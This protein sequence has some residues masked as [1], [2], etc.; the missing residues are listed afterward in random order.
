MM[1]LDRRLQKR[2]HA[3]L[4]LP[5]SSPPLPGYDQIRMIIRSQVA[6]YILNMRLKMNLL[7][8]SFFSVL[9]SNVAVA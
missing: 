1:R 4:S 6:S 5:I 2:R 3:S 9:P 8:P 7:L